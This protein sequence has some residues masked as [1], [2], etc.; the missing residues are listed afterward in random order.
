[1]GIASNQKREILIKLLLKRDEDV[2]D[3]E[4]ISENGEEEVE[5]AGSEISLDVVIDSV[6]S[7]VESNDKDISD[8][9]KEIVK[10]V[11]S[12]TLL[13]VVN[14]FVPS[15]VEAI[16][17]DISDGEADQTSLSKTLYS[18][19]YRELQVGSD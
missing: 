13:D 16:D 17:E 5:Q 18:C 19:T 4:D 10:Q 11:E 7:E 1:M 9:G 12:E 8:R 6:P 14:D 15:E 3:K 2:N